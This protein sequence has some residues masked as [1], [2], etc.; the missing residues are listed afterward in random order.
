MQLTE[1]D[2]HILQSDLFGFSCFANVEFPTEL[3]EWSREMD[4][5]EQASSNTFYPFQNKH[6]IHQDQ[7]LQIDEM[8]YPLEKSKSSRNP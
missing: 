5:V 6:Q 7:H 8:L 2:L 4:Y 1:E 3:L